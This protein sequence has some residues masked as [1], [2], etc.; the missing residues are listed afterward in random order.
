MADVFLFTGLSGA[1]KTTLAQRFGAELQAAGYRVEL[2]DGDVIRRDLCSDLGFSK[3]DRIENVRRL[4]EA[5]IARRQASA[6]VVIIAA[7]APYCCSREE[8][9]RQVEAQA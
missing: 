1:G 8:L 4:G 3:A 2:L 5:A 6:E 7:I 9:R